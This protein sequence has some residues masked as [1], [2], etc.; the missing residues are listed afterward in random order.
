[1]YHI[2]SYSCNQAQMKFT[3]YKRKH[4]INNNAKA[5]KGTNSSVTTMYQ[6]GLQK[7]PSIQFSIHNVMNIIQEELTVRLQEDYVKTRKK[8][9]E[10]TTKRKK[11]FISKKKE[12]EVFSNF[13]ESVTL[14][15]ITQQRVDFLWSQRSNRS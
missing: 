11:S 3:I 5:K 1:M 9:K 14:G 10:K 6:F 12:K 2:L 8:K 7:C 15:Q 13:F 4:N